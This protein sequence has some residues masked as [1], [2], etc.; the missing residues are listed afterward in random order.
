[1]IIGTVDVFRREA[2]VRLHLQAPNGIIHEV[3]AVLDTGFT[4]DLTLPSDLITTLGLLRLR[5]DQV[6]LSDGSLV[7]CAIHEAAVL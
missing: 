2:L 5:T 3:E 7:A 4:D 6:Q 1:M